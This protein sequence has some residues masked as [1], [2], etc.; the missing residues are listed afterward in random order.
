MAGARFPLDFWLGYW[1]APPLRS[2]ADIILMIREAAAD[3]EVK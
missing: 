3:W 1:R 2:A